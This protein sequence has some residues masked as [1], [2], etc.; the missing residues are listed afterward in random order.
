MKLWTMQ[1]IEVYNI[2]LRDGVF[3]CD[4]DQVDMPEFLKAYDWLNIHLNNKDP[5]PDNVS[6]PIWAWYRFND[7]EKKPDLRHTCYGTRGQKMVC[8]ELEV[9]DEKVLLSD[10]D[11]WH[12]VLNDWWLDNCFYQEYREKDYDKNHQWF[13]SLCPEKQR[14]LKNSSW[15]QIFNIGRYESDWISRGK[16][17]Q[18]VFWELKK[19]YVK[20]VQY[21]VAR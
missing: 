21:F 19:E 2:L 6:Y 7:M 1:P 15:L 8:L 12:W 11:L 13:K 5:K 18:A 9:P 3:I 14:E 17:I 10:F 20:K 16:Y 4:P